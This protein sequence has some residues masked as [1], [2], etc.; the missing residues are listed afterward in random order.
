MTDR[1]EEMRRITAGPYALFMLGENLV[2][3]QWAIEEIESLRDF[4]GK[5]DECGKCLYEM[6][7]GP[8]HNHAR[9]LKALPMQTIR[10]IG[11]ILAAGTRDGESAPTKFHFEGG[12]PTLRG[13]ITKEDK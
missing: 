6:A 4:L 12:A 11:N 13:A 2:V 8:A 10:F 1:L 5:C 9:E 7:C 3:L